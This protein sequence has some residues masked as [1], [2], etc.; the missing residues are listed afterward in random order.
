MGSGTFSWAINRKL[1][2]NAK[3]VYFLSSAGP[4]VILASLGVGRKMC[5]IHFTPLQEGGNPIGRDSNFDSISLG[6]DINGNT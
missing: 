6:S 5:F 3:A 1:G 2:K 4:A